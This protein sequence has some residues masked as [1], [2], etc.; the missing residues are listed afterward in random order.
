MSAPRSHSK[1]TSRE[2]RVCPHF[3]HLYKRYQRRAE[4][5]GRS[6]ELTQAEFRAI[7]KM[8]CHY[9][10]KPPAQAYNRYSNKRVHLLIKNQ[11]YVYNGI[12]R[13]S[14]D[15][16]YTLENVVPC[17]GTCNKM[18]LDMTVGEFHEQI[19]KITEH[20]KSHHDPGS[21]VED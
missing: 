9:C 11:P 12:D 17:C 5:K 15:L 6:F 8:D 13:V 20:T 4:Q 1:G 16:G 3:S 2:Q 21:E 10:G 18:K 7:T 19:Q 14:S